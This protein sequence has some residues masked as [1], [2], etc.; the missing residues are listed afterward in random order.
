MIE[1]GKIKPKPL[2]EY[3]GVEMEVTIHDLC[4][5]VSEL[6]QRVEALEKVVSDMKQEVDLTQPFGDCCND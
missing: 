5:A 4:I 1:S 3:L 2:R 6:T